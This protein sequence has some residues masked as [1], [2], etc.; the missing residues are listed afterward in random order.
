[1]PNIPYQY[2]TAGQKARLSRGGS[3]R[4]SYGYSPRRR[5]YGNRGSNGFSGYT[6]GSRRRTRRASSTAYYYR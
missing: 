2:L 1:M 6:S 5:S 4:R 3:R